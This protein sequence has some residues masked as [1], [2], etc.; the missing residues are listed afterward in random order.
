MPDKDRD[1]RAR[2]EHKPV[3]RAQAVSLPGQQAAKR[4]YKADNSNNNPSKPDI[5]SRAWD[6]ASHGLSHHGAHPPH[7]SPSPP[8]SHSRSSRSPPQPA[9]PPLPSSAGSPRIPPDRPA[10]KGII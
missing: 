4:D 3:E 9:R 8:A 7:P 10:G 2:K 1:R 5:F 6:N